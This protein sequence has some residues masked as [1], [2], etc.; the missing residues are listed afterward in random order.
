MTGTSLSL[1]FYNLAL[2]IVVTPFKTYRVIFLLLVLFA[3]SACGLLGTRHPEMHGRILH[4]VHDKPLAHTEVVALWKGTEQQDKT[5]K[6]I[7]YHVE[8]AT[9]DDKGF[10]SI[11]E[12]R[13][14]NTYKSL[15]NKTIEVYAFRKYY[16]TSELTNQVL[17]DK[18]FNYYLAKP[19]HIE[20]KNKAREARLRYLQLLLGKTTC[21]LKGE[22]RKNLQPLFIAIIKEA[23]GLAVTKK[24]KA[25][26]KKL[27]GWL[28]FISAEEK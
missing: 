12:W 14:P 2:L 8:S 1:L 10:V 5:E 27:K 24:D 13:E 16:R 15:K 23:S 25:V 19:R 28:Q 26:V 21:D 11:P 6:R 9:A 4:E 3:I 22:S 18:N 17:T 20:N 7:C